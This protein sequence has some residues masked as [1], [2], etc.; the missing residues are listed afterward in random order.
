MGADQATDDHYN[1]EQLD[2]RQDWLCPRVE[3]EHAPKHHRRL[4]EGLRPE[5]HPGELHERVGE[6]SEEEEHHRTRVIAGETLTQPTLGSEVAA[7]QPS[8]DH[9]GPARSMPE[10]AE[11]HR[12][13]QIE[14]SARRTVTVAAERNVEIVAQPRRQCD[15]PAPPEVREA[16]GRVR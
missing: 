10:T 11:Q 13:E 15:V 6:E 8:P 5:E 4:A 12:R 7:V 1:H 2:A 9:E 3:P 16:D 14:V